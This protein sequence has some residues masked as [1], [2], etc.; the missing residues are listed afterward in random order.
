M[1]F[2]WLDC[3]A[4]LCLLLSALPD[5]QAWVAPFQEVGGVNSP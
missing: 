1:S 2:E 3:S 5:L 4:P